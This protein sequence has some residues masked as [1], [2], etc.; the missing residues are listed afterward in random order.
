MTYS[1]LV[2]KLQKETGLT[3]AQI[4]DVLDGLRDAVHSGEDVSLPGLGNF[5]VVMRTARKG[6]NPR[7]GEKIDIPKKRVPRFR[8]AKALKE[9]VA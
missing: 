8:A 5:S 7:T 6:R 9:A 2:S 3:K 4:D 1:K